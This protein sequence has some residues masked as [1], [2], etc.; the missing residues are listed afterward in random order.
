MGEAKKRKRRVEREIQRA[1]RAN[2][3][4]LESGLQ[5]ADD[6]KELTV[7]YGGDSQ[8]G[9][10]DITAKD[11]TGA[12]VVIELKRE[13]AG[14]RAVGQVL[15]YMGAL[16]NHTKKVRGILVAKKFSPQG[17]AAAR[18]VPSLRLVKL[19]SLSLKSPK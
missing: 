10:I 13:K 1:I 15:G 4:S 9:H 7:N 19:K 16:M 3:D 5:I 6:G 2:I 14:R 18:A 8:P 12:T 11:K 17:E